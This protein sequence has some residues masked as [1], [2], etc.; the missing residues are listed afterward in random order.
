MAQKRF[1]NYIGHIGHIPDVAPGEVFHRRKNVRAAGLHCDDVRGISN[2]ADEDGLDVADAIVL[3]GGYEDD[4]DHWQRIRYTGEGGRDESKRLVSSQDWGHPRNAALKRSYERKYP[5]RIIRGY[6]G[7]PLYSL[8]DD[9]RYDGL[10]EITAIRTAIST[11]VALDGSPL[12]ICQYDMQRLPA[13]Q[14]EITPLEREA[15][16]LFD[17]ESEEKFPETRTT[18]IERLVRDSA[19]VRRVK[20]IYNS[21]CQICGIS[22]LG[23][24]G[25]RRSEGA[26][27]RPLAKPHEGPD[28]ERN[29]LC[30]CPNCHVRL[31]SGGIY[32][33]DDWRVFEISSGVEPGAFIAELTLKKEHG[34]RV[35]YAQYHRNWWK[36]KL[37]LPHGEE[38]P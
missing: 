16:A 21:E 1:S 2:F 18:I 29:I 22:L 35:D 20:K 6:N 15:A 4:E 3:N 11:T 26:H 33:T 10:Y 9:Y 37:N 36:G 38:S 8:P 25:K 34:V 13:S 14:Q 23:A 17:L 19:V 7:D 28:V 27:I 32:I 5:I 12:S 24:D 30:L 31:D